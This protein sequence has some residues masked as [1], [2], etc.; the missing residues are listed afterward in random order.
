MSK[1]PDTA[2]KSAAKP[3]LFKVKLLKEHKHGGEPKKVGDTIEVTAPERDF[4]RK[5]GV[6]ASEPTNEAAAPAAE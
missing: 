4:L 3:E 1:Q 6:I 5:H 2:A